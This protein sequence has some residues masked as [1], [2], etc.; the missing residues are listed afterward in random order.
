VILDSS[1]LVALIFEEATADWVQAQIDSEAVVDLRMSWVNVAEAG[2][3]C[4]RRRAGGARA[5]VTAIAELQLDMLQPDAATVMAAVEA[6]QRFPL[7]FGDCFAYAHALLLGEPLLTLDDDFLKTDL[8]QV[9]HPAA[10]SVRRGTS[11]RGP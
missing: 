4:E 11:S 8:A 5:V 10:G 1:A 7:N 3:T 2:M 9:L 6:R